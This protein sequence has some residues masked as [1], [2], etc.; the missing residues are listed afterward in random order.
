[1][2]LF[3]IL[4]ISLIVA[5][6]FG[7]T[8]I[9]ASDVYSVLMHEIFG[10]GDVETLG[11]GNIY[12]VVIFIRL[13][14]L[15]LAVAVGIALSVGGAVTQAVVKN[16]IADPYVLGISSGGYLGATLAL[17]LGM[18]SALGGNAMGIM[19]FIGAF[20][21]SVGVMT[22]A[23]LGAKSGA[24][25]LIL[26]GV[27]FSAVCSAV[28]NFA[29]LMLND[30]SAVSIVHWSMGGLGGAEWESNFIILGVAL[31][32]TVFLITQSRSLNL[33]LMGDDTAITLGVNLRTK[34][35]VYMLVCSV[36][37]GFV[38]FKAGMIGFVGLIIPHIVRMIFGTEHSRLIPASALLGAIFMVW[39]DVLCRVLVPGNEI[40]VGIITAMV[41]APVFI[42]LV[43]VKKYGFGGGK[44]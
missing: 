18:G 22:V 5:V 31:L 21:V 17:A 4:I 23:N 12:D 27:A 41:G 34:R 37:I 39:A 3:A 26:T 14:R 2:G 25:K 10:I 33:M 36:M 7:S 9:P 30:A 13:P 1:M 29:I 24:V 20:A 38:V 11:S 28:A 42:Y 16:P 19:A 40:P 6:G 44:T 8:S 15:I 43:V 32:G 35:V